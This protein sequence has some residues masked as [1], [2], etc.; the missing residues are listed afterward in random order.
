MENLNHN[1]SKKRRYSRFGIIIYALKQ[2][3]RNPT[4]EQMIVNLFEAA[5]AKTTEL[6]LPKIKNW[7]YGNPSNTGYTKYFKNYSKNNDESVLNFFESTIGD[8][9]VTR[10]I[11]KEYEN[12]LNLIDFKTDDRSIFYKSLLN[13][14][15][16]IVGVPTQTVV[17]PTDQMKEILN[18]A[19]IEC[20]LPY[21]LQ[22]VTAFW[23]QGS[24]ALQSF[25]KLDRIITNKILIPFANY[26][27]VEMF[28]K[29]YNFNQL[30]TSIISFVPFLKP[31]V[32]D[33]YVEDWKYEKTVDEC[34]AIIN[35]EIEK[36]EKSIQE[37]DKYYSDRKEETVKVH[38]LFNINAELPAEFLYPFTPVIDWGSGEPIYNELTQEEISTQL[39]FLGTVLKFYQ[40]I[41]KLYEDIFGCKPVWYY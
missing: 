28:K 33:L 25:K 26:G 1:E 30:L 14:F 13:Q 23:K 38:C 9:E 6:D 40:E 34:L 19:V 39:R 7:F 10:S 8:F 22:D 2:G 16:E 3:K 5:D 32:V 29:I 12:E 27:H 31:S 37:R 41:I 15:K 17:I 11:L 4:R 18:K 24:T 21:H 20:E 36:I 35:D